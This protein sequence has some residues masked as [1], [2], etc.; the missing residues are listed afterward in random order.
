MEVEL[1][2]TITAA[3]A[4]KFIWRNIFTRF[5]IPNSVVTDNGTQ[6]INQKFQCFLASYKVKHHFTFV[7]TPKPM[8]KSKQ[9][10]R[11]CSED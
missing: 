9:P 10:T 6:L 5:R 11:S 2:S 3:Q 4:W 7:S 8:V 1:L